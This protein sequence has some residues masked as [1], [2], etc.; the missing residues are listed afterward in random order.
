MLH[1]M[2]LPARARAPKIGLFAQTA[3][4]S[5]CRRLQLALQGVRLEAGML[6]KM[7]LLQGIVGAVVKP[8]G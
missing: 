2:D 6:H 3:W 7:G 8:A 5:H 1:E 4:V